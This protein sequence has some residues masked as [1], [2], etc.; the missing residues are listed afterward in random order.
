MESQ[1]SQKKIAKGGRGDMVLGLLALAALVLGYFLYQKLKVPAPKIT[2]TNSAETS[3]ER[4]V[5]RYPA[6]DVTPGEWNNYLVLVAKLAMETDTVTVG[7]NCK[8]TPVVVKTPLVSGKKLHFK[9]SDTV[10]HEIAF[11]NPPSYAIAAN[12]TVDIPIDFKG[13]PGIYGYGCD[14]SPNAV[15]LVQVLQ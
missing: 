14:M 5:L 10:A 2:T 4:A 3:D 11:T 9:N 7:P 13:V 15:G 1:S 6:R 12:S 8:I